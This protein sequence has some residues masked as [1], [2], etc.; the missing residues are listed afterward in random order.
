MNEETKQTSQEESPLEEPA[1]KSNAGNNS[2]ACA[3]LAYFAI[4]IVWYF[5]D[6]QLKQNKFAHFHVK[7]ALG[8]IIFDIVVM[9]ALAIS[10]IGFIAMPLVNLFVLVLAVIG[11]INA[12]N[13]EEKDLPIIGAYSRKYLKF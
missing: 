8:L 3:V 7:Q 13:N 10:V 4:G 6:A 9:T 11:I 5:V 12:L 2:K 1:T